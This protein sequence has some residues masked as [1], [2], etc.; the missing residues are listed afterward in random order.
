MLEKLKLSCDGGVYGN[1]NYVQGYGEVLLQTALGGS[2][3]SGGRFF[4]SCVW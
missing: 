4:C 2:L 1:K 3:K